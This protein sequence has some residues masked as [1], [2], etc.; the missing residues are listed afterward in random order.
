MNFHLENFTSLFCLRVGR[1]FNC[2]TALE[3]E[4]RKSA[5]YIHEQQYQETVVL[6]LSH[7]KPKKLDK[8]A[9]NHFNLSSIT[10]LSCEVAVNAPAVIYVLCVSV[11]FL[12]SEVGSAH[13]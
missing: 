12:V 3:R 11:S 4:Y 1:E 10:G 8:T 9:T 2:F 5:L 13:S 6:G 7:G